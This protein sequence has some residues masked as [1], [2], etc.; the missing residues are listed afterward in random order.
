MEQLVTLIY[1]E[2]RVPGQSANTTDVKPAL[3]L[4]AEGFASVYTKNEA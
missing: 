4:A 2:P 1:A 3:E